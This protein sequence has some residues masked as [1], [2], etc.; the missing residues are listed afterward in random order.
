MGGSNGYLGNA[1]MNRDFYSV[2][3]PLVGSLTCGL[4][5]DALVADMGQMLMDGSTQDKSGG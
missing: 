3:L 1:Q 5:R 4:T 2:G